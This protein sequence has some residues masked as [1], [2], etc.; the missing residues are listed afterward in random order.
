MWSFEDR[1]RD[2]NRSLDD[3][4][5]HKVRWCAGD[6]APKGD[7]CRFQLVSS[8]FAPSMQYRARA[9]G[10]A[11]PFGSAMSEVDY[12]VSAGP[13][14]ENTS[15]ESNLRPLSAYVAGCDRSASICINSI[16]GCP[17]ISAELPHARNP[18]RWR[19][20]PCSSW[21]TG[22]GRGH[23]AW[24]WRYRRH[25]GACGRDPGPKPYRDRS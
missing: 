16:R 4:V 23:V 6:G 24:L 14:E 2:G 13:A 10:I 9:A 25:V 18:D 8:N 3:L 1:T 17:T 12:C 5:E 19:D 21:R 20:Y 11:R 22:A 7:V 15:H